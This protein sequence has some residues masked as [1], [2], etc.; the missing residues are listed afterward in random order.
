MSATSLDELDAGVQR[1][2][3]WR[4]VRI[5][6]SIIHFVEAPR[7]GWTRDLVFAQKASLWKTQDVAA[8]R[9][10][11]FVAQLGAGVSPSSPSAPAEAAPDGLGR[12]TPRCRGARPTAF[13]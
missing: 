8:Q 2:P 9:C 11:T 6:E 3:V 12:C 10:G 7:L 4:C 5:S 13:P 1:S